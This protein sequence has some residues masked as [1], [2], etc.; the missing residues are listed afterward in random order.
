MGILLDWVLTVQKLAQNKLFSWL[1]SSLVRQIGWMKLRHA[2]KTKGMNQ[3]VQQ[4]KEATGNLFK[5]QVR[6]TRS[7][8]SQ[9]PKMTTS[10][11]A[12]MIS[13]VHDTD[14]DKKSSVASFAQAGISRPNIAMDSNSSKNAIR[15]IASVDQRRR[16]MNQSRRTL[17]GTGS[18]LS[19]NPIQE[20]D[21]NSGRNHRKAIA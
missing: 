13:L 2:I 9:V 10:S 17:S 4:F 3:L 14:D 16:R 12:S 6:L 18:Q 19:F 8:W 20:E 5:E 7:V 1:R 15:T 21:E 11:R